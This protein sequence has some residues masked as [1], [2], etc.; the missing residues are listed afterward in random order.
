MDNELGRILRN[1]LT[2]LDD[3]EIAQGDAAGLP[4]EFE[5]LAAAAASVYLHHFGFLDEAPEYFGDE[6][7]H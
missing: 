2:D 7:V 5:A 6:A 4:V 3:Y 1:F